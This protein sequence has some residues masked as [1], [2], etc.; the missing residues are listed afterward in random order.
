MAAGLSK[1]EALGSE[2]GNRG[3]AR[4]NAHLRFALTTGLR[5][6]AH[7]NDN[8]NRKKG[9]LLNSLDTRLASSLTVRLGGATLQLLRFLH[10]ESLLRT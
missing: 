5:F 8:I 7:S 2:P 6:S 10:L 1:H 4:W 3:A 9:T